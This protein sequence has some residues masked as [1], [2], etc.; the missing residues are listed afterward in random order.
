MSTSNLY[1]TPCSPRLISDSFQE[2]TNISKGISFTLDQLNF[3]NVERE[4]FTDIS[5]IPRVQDLTQHTIQKYT[6]AGS[7]NHIHQSEIERITRYY[8]PK[9]LTSS[10][11]ER[12]NNELEKL[13]LENKML[14]KCI[15][16]KDDLL[17]GYGTKV[18]N[19][20]SQVAITWDLTEKLKRVSQENEELTETLQDRLGAFK[21]TLK[22]L[23][24][25]EAKLKV[26]NQDKV[27][28]QTLLEEALKELEESKL[29]KIQLQKQFSNKTKEIEDL[30][31]QLTETEDKLVST[32]QE[33]KR[34][35][36]SLVSSPQ[37]RTSVGSITS[38]IVTSPKNNAQ[39]STSPKK[40]SA[41]TPK[42]SQSPSKNKSKEP[43]RKGVQILQVL[44]VHKPTVRTETSPSHSPSPKKKSHQHQKSLSGLSKIVKNQSSPFLKREFANLNI[45]CK[46]T[47]ST[48]ANSPKSMSFMC[49]S[50]QG[51]F[52]R[53]DSP[54]SSNLRSS[55]SFTGGASS[56]DASGN[57]S[58]AKLSLGE[59]KKFSQRLTMLAELEEQESE[60]NVV[61]TPLTRT[62]SRRETVPVFNHPIKE[63]DGEDVENTHRDY[64]QE[65]KRLVSEI[66]TKVGLIWIENEILD[67]KVAEKNQNI[68]RLEG[69]IAEIGV[70][71]EKLNGVLEEKKT[72]E[73]ALQKRSQEVDSLKIELNESQSSQEGYK[74]FILERERKQSLLAQKLNEAEARIKGL[75]R[76]EGELR[77][78]VNRA[79]S[80]LVT[81]GNERL[82]SSLLSKYQ[83]KSFKDLE[84]DSSS[85]SAYNLKP[86]TK[87]TLVDL[88]TERAR[89]MK[90]LECISPLLPMDHR[91]LPEPLFAKRGNE[92]TKSQSSLISET[93][94]QS[95]PV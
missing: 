50:P 80:V 78:V 85:N 49:P 69:K 93:S 36:Q 17:K 41:K 19:L 22:Q 65:F 46:T 26:S 75:S 56:P 90:D 91:N 42:G 63:E 15:E 43:K 7:W 37:N 55:A 21:G 58:P 57:S 25:L 70:A 35:T 24:N 47:S 89:T 92:T 23:E 28:F 39:K 54:R 38:F 72:L 76:V 10:A 81:G 84:D 64:Q 1:N 59:D 31:I 95:G 73:N 53:D 5:S 51:F 94:T 4:Q 16:E 9:Q 71:E 13:R 40:V 32:A 44:K 79:Q 12:P 18:A 67:K 20:E 8:V 60:Q 29:D 87:S 62:K 86:F 61:A 3:T 68:Q 6:D 11:T 83:S 27:K 52:S 74:Q 2:S 66:N 34:M 45:S 82:N 48:R 88:E 30:S 33:H 14:K 77:V